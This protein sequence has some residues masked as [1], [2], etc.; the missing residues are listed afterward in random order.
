MSPLTRF[1][2]WLYGEPNSVAGQGVQSSVVSTWPWPAW[3]MLVL[4]LGSVGL[5]VFVYVRERIE[6]GRATKMLLLA[7]RVLLV[8]LVVFMLYGW[9]RHRYRTDLPDLIVVVDDSASMALVDHYEDERLRAALA[10][11]L[12]AAKLDELSRLNLA[13]LLLL[14]RDHRL[15]DELN[16][17]YQLKIYWLGGTARAVSA[18]AAELPQAVRRQT[19]EQSASRLGAGIRNILE[20]QRG[21][22]TAAVIV[23]TDGITTEG[24]S[25][26]ETADYARRKSVPLYVIGIGSSQ[27]P[28]DVRLSDLLADEVAFAG[29]LVN[30]DFKLSASG[31]AGKSVRLR[32]RRENSSETLAEKTE[33]LGDDETTA[34]VRL[35]YRPVEKGELRFVV[36]AE[37]LP[38]EADLQNNRLTQ[39]INVRDET[40]RVLLVQEY[41][42]FEFR[43]LKTLLEREVEQSDPTRQSIELTSVLQEADRQYAEL[44]KSARAVFPVR[45]DELFAYDVIVFGDVNPAFLSR[46]I[47]ENLA[48]FVKERGGGMVFM[49]G[50][51]HTPL[52]YRD[53]PLAELFPVELSSASI[54]DPAINLDRAFAVQPARLGLA[55]PQMQ[56]RPTLSQNVALWRDLPGLY[57]MVEAPDLRPGARVLAEHP[58]RTGNTGQPLPVIAMQFVG[59]GKVIFHATDETYRWGRYRGSDQAYNQYWIQTLR[60][61][62]RSKLLGGSRSV[63]MTTDRD[64]YR[65]GDVVLLRVRF[66]DERL[67]PEQDDG[68]AVVLEREGGTRRQVTLTRDPTM[69]GVFEAAIGDLADGTYRAWMATPALEG[70]P[71]HARFA[72]VAPPGEQARLQ[73]D[74]A[75]LQRAAKTSRGKY[76]TLDQADRL[77]RDLPEGRQVRIE[78]LPPEPIWNTW[79]LPALFTTLIA[80][81]WLLRK[82]VGL[83]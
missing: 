80:S 5:V 27:P 59:G 55:S 13:K 25:L 39:T 34:S 58:T 82:R 15:L 67:A 35:S 51:R 57:W 45:R 79:L 68:V 56:L 24:R 69:R 9:M 12:K 54:P 43:Y 37:P 46:S 14:E 40:L 64:E 52:A 75:D 77:T 36:E 42:S 11:R 31:Y 63:E 29:D 70:Q 30:F 72:V 18:E 48:A 22:P 47:M 8:A 32:L 62:S 21:R 2:E 10:K 49:S 50:P 61:L 71:P 20:T 60:Y 76:Y 38:G 44:D 7:I 33:T 65:R 41:P 78:S 83:L 81:E 1:L 17:R 4:F 73:A 66:F 19:P 23:L 28:R 16:E 6:A 3:V 26:S 74:L 53:T